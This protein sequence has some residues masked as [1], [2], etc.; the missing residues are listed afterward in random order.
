MDL[1]VALSLL[2]LAPISLASLDHRQATPQAWKSVGCYTDTASART[3][4]GATFTNSSMTVDA[5]FAFCETDQYVFAGV[6]FGKQCFC[7]YAIQSP[8]TA[9]SPGECT[10]PCGG[11]SSE[12]CGAPNRINLY[13]NE[14]PGPSVLPSFEVG[15]RTW[16]YVGC[17]ADNTSERTLPYQA[18]STSGF[19]ATAEEVGCAVVCDDQGYYY[20]GTEFGSE[21]WCGDEIAPSAT[22]APD[23]DCHFACAADSTHS[24]FCGGRERLTV[25]HKDICDTTSISNVFLIAFFGQITPDEFR[26]SVDVIGY[27]L[28]MDTVDD[29]HYVLSAATC[30]PEC[31]GA[32]IE[33]SIANK[34]LTTESEPALGAQAVAEGESPVFALNEPPHPIYCQTVPNH[35]FELPVL[36]LNGR[37]D[38]WALCPNNTVGG[39]LDVVFAPVANHPHYALNE[40]EVVYIQIVESS[41][42]C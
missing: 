13:T 36:T 29:I 4:A 15:I 40:C 7:D 37:A 35:Q 27:Y 16:D 30:G 12:I 21:C 28:I 10:L 14:L 24:E 26:R 25:F 11:N 42:E 5:C 34:V 38:Q 19:F 9:T 17:F 41:F 8:G 23:S 1:V 20:A 18:T 3:L 2:S 6:E 31:C 39:R 33:L 22:Q 32:G